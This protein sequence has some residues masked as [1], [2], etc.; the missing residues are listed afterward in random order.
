M[1]GKTLSKLQVYSAFET[2]G[3]D[4]DALRE[5]INPDALGPTDYIR[6]VAP[7]FAVVSNCDDPDAVALSGGDV[8]G[9]ALSASISPISGVQTAPAQPAPQNPA[10]A[11]AQ[12]A[13]AQTAPQHPAPTPAPQQSSGLSVGGS[14]IAL[15][16]PAPQQSSG[17]SVGGSGI[18]LG[19]ASP[20]A[21]STALPFP[22]VANSVPFPGVGA[23]AA[24]S[25][26]DF[27]DD[28]GETLAFVPKTTGT[29]PRLFRPA[30]RG[31]PPELPE[32]TR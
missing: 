27:T 16:T 7:G 28:A 15:G 4:S 6:E 24:P 22:G 12:P 30:A 32:E 5:V 14:G 13:P 29:Q 18:A 20:A 23:P 26:D 25:D 9:A 19:A 8:D 10:P 2:E 17:L 3:R 31:A 21:A 11:P 1:G